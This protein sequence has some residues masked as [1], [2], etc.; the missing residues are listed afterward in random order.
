M[1]KNLKKLIK[2]SYASMPSLLNSETL[3]MILTDYDF[4][5]N[6]VCV[7]YKSVDQEQLPE[8]FTDLHC[9]RSMLDFLINKYK[10]DLIRKTDNMESSDI[11]KDEEEAIGKLFGQVEDFI[12]ENICKILNL[13]IAEREENYEKI[14]K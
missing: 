10:L 9:R 2:Q 13:S 6:E 11:S 1:N 8:N 3:A 12:I 5:K 14:I 7:R 4:K